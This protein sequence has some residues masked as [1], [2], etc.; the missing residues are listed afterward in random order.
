MHATH[1]S[2]STPDFQ[3]LFE[4]APGL[5]LVVLPDIPRYTIVAVSDA[6]ARA[7]MTLREEIV[8]R[9][10]FDVFP[11]N[12]AD[13]TATGVSELRDSLGRVLTM[14]VPD[15]M[16]V[17]RYAIRRSSESGAAFEERW[18][19]SSNSPVLG[20]D[21]EVAY[22][23]HAIE[24]VTEKH[25]LDEERQLFAALV[26]NSSDFI[27][28][29]D[30]SGKPTY[31]NP[32]GRRMVG[33]PPDYP[34]GET[35][36]VEYYPDSERAFASDVIVKEMVERG[37]W[38][39]E[40]H[41]RNWKTGASIPV[42]DEHFMIRDAG[43]RVLGMGTITRDISAAKRAAAERERLLTLANDLF[44]QASDAIYIADMHGRLTEV[45]ATA[46][47][48]LGYAR[49]ELIGKS[50]V[51]IV[52]PEDI[53]RL[54]PARE[55]LLSEGAVQVAEWTTLKK[56]GT[57][58]L[59]EASAKILADGRWQA[60]VR[61]IGD[62]KR[63]ERALQES[64][65]RFR[66]TI[67]EA[68][69]GM[70]LVALDGRFVRVNRVL[71]EIVGYE[72]AELT[73]LTFQAITHPDDLDADLALAGQ[74]ARGEIPRYQLEKRYI[75]KNGTIV[76]ILLSASILRSRRGA[77]LY[78]IVQI[79]D[80]TERKQAQEALRRSES[81]YRGLIEEMPDGVFAYRGGRIA[82][83]NAAFARLLGYDEPAA[84]VG[85]T[86]FELLHPDD[87]PAVG[88]RIRAV[89]QTGLPAPPR[90]FR[91]LGRDGTFRNVETVGIQAQFE[92]QS[93][94]VVIVRDLTQRKQAEEALQRSERDF[95]EL[96]ESMPQIV[97]V[98][99]PDGWNIYF[100]QQW[101]DYTG[102]T[103]EESYGE[104]WII[105][106]HPDDRQRAWDAWQHATQ[107]RGTYSLEC[108]LRRADGGYRW[109]L[110]RGVPLLGPNGEITKWFGTCTD[111]EDIKV[112]EQRLKE[113][114]A[115]FS[116]IISI[117]ADAIISTGD[118]Q[119]IT[120]F[121][122]GAEQIF[123]Y[124]E[125][126]AIGLPLDDLIPE[127]FRTAHRQHVER[128]A[129]G[130]ATARRMGERLTTIAG[131]RKNGE[132]FPAEA[133]ISKLQVGE[134]TLLTVALRDVTERRRIE[135]ELKA[136]NASLD[137]IIENI[138]LM[139]FIK[140]S[141]SLRFVR[142]N[143]AGEDLLGWPRE[144][145]I[146]KCD[147]DFWPQEQAEFFVA[148]DREALSGGTVVDIP[149]EPVQTRHQGVRLLHT[150]KVP[151]L[152]SAGRPS[153]LL[154]ISEDIT[155]RSRLEKEQRFLVEANVMLSASL[156]Y[157][158]TLASVARLAVQ[159]VADWC[160]VDLVDEHGHL[161]RLNVTS[162]DPA[163]AALR[164]ALAEMAP[165]PIVR[166]V[167]ESKRPLIIEHITPHFVESMAKDPKTLQALLA[168]EVT[169][170][171]A[172]PLMIRGEPIGALVFG[173]SSPTHVYQQDD[174][175]L[176]EALADRAAMAIENARLYRGSVNAAQLRDQ[177]LGVVAHDLRN[178]LSTILLQAAAL[179]RRGPEPER[180]SAKPSEAIHRAATRMNRLIQDLL[181]VA[182]MESGQLTIE[183]ARLSTRELIVGAVETQRPLAASSA[184]DLRIDVDP[185]LPNVWGDRDRLLQVFENL[186]GNAIKFTE[187]GGSVTVGAASRDDEIVFWV[188]DTGG[189][190]APENLP[191]VFDRFWQA[192]RAGRQGAGLGLPIAKGIVEAHGGRIWVESTEGRGTT[193]SFTIPKATPEPSSVH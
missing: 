96:A 122:R 133:A 159:K 70:A 35:Q 56:D 167:M 73:G 28:I 147:Y 75:R 40:T 124:S 125:A 165:G 29:A 36:I 119:R 101:V 94:I 151:I 162:A 68:P 116:G 85:R 168:T 98:T 43:G 187:G 120:I 180:R 25:H 176:A 67:D 92:G 137:A 17:H 32:A 123:G 84:L 57:P 19:T 20:P 72:P 163:K 157:E 177:V 23:I 1:T 86:V 110:I 141:Q 155:E 9:G 91:M 154:G 184:L 77:P 33:L 38:S 24:D 11:D 178:P 12:P 111:I 7:T 97:W 79:E 114:E 112:A 182:L 104:G 95:R 189:G 193:F 45:N 4:A 170:L 14:R 78:Y 49:E 164:A 31:L 42:S 55:Y 64:E 54:A 118:D 117:S 99:R 34:V 90:E 10:L 3:T 48:M 74:L 61:N 8:G 89:L 171:M 59:V 192:T 136:A 37:H 47:R 6:Y 41:F 145:F 18:W 5:Y 169:S 2:Q 113:S 143:R 129:S 166:S 39:G 15:A 140:E 106:F 105:P 131:V 148:K 186:I 16:P 127:R 44:D 156:D 93:S 135:A 60:F 62:R 161:K 146:G 134:K 149:E 87:H 183:P 138:P 115:K 22:I 83:A 160:A 158:Q 76:D 153:Y 172:V 173:S 21:G 58:V 108:R 121:N 174:L 102:L 53:P 107:H 190:I 51:D 27:G 132:E 185:G 71:C 80:I 103:L 30:P 188:A 13:P 82:Y 181:D 46:C 191:L 63:V 66:L 26:E 81:Q 128:F 175:R 152:D 88:E 109:W 150:K 50:V 126:E 142:F 179:K 100:N 130:D 144:T 69:I 65:E 139:L 52:S